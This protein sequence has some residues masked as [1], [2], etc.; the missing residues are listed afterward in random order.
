MKPFSSLTS[1]AI[2]CCLNSN[3]KPEANGVN[4]FY[5]TVKNYNSAMGYSIE[6][7]VTKDS[8]KMFSNCDFLNC[9]EEIIYKQKLDEESSRSFS[10]TI[11]DIKIDSLKTKYVNEGFDGLIRT[12]L[13]Q[14]N[15]DKLK[16][17][18]L[19][20]YN[21]PTIDTLVLKIKNLIT[22]EEYKNMI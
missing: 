1:I 3:C 22:D 10:K 2:V 16:Y 15:A 7:L 21:H 11:S 4:S 20:R 8:L 14:K 9:E 13:F 18:R 5:I 19:E 12:V 17:I 6:Y